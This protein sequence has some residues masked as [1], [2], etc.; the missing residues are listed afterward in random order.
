MPYDIRKPIAQW[1]EHNS[2]GFSVFGSGN[3]SERRQQRLLLF[4]RKTT[5]LKP[6]GGAKPYP[7]R[8]CGRKQHSFWDEKA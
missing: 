5:P 8:V 3:L 6:L 7:V 4:F 1:R 2:G